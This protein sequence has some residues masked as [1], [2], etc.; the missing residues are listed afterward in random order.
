[1]NES[2]ELKEKESSFDNETTYEVME[3][4]AHSTTDDVVVVMSDKQV[5]TTIHERAGR[6]SQILFVYAREHPEIGYRQGMHEV[7]DYVM[8]A[9]EGD[10]LLSEEE[11]TM[12]LKKGTPNVVMEHCLVDSNFILHDAFTL[13]ECIMA[14]LATAYDANPHAVEESGDFY[15]QKFLEQGESSPL[16]NLTA[17]IMT[18]LQLVEGDE[19]LCNILLNIMPVPPNLYFAKWIRLM[20]VREISGGMENALN[21]LD[22]FFDLAWSVTSYSSSELPI[23]VA[24][25]DVWKAAA[26]GMI[27]LIRHKLVP[28]LINNGTMMGQHALDPNIGVGYLMNYPPLEDAQLLVDT[29]VELLIK[30]KKLSNAYFQ[31]LSTATKSPMKLSEDQLPLCSQLV[32]GASKSSSDF[33]KGEYD[34]NYPRRTTTV[35]TNAQQQMLQSAEQ[36]RKHRPSPPLVSHER[37]P[38]MKQT[39]APVSFNHG[40]I[41]GTIGNIAEGIIDFSKTASAAITS[42]HKQFEGHVSAAP[43][44]GHP[45]QND[46]M[47]LSPS[48][49]SLSPRNSL[50]ELASTLETSTATLMKYFT[51]RINATAEEEYMIENSCRTYDS[52]CRSSS[53]PADIWEAITNIDLVRKELLKQ[54]A[55][56]SRQKCNT[57]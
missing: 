40:P 56:N 19:Q 31:S 51:E 38:G 46:V 12:T 14:S 28:T 5:Q 10:I 7:L 35:S 24:L 21:L 50:M 49:A 17:S 48:T 39:P 2:Q 20:F 6:M 13:F 32:A 45:L 41:S 36:G 30:E 53:I 52:N 57:F 1:M 43:F 44:L 15:S 47:I 34:N 18:K 11:K 42:F 55:E 25:L 33:L 3:H 26:C 29:I 54:Q 23:N 16:E 4:Q 9:F 8:L 37:I 22:A 27:L